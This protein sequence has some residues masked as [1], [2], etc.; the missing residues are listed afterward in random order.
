M[1]FRLDKIRGITSIRTINAKKIYEH[2][3]FRD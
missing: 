2:L 3:D 1:I